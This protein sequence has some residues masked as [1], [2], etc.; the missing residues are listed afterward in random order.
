MSGTPS[1]VESSVGATSVVA[2]SGTVLVAGSL[3]TAS[4]TTGSEVAGA[5]VAAGV[6]SGTTVPVPR[7]LEAMAVVWFRSFPLPLFPPPRSPSRSLSF[8]SF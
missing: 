5:A 6:Y 8:W 7:L 2:G 3:T 4:G 1:V